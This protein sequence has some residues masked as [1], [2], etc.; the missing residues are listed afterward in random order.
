MAATTSSSGANQPPVVPQD[1]RDFINP[2][3]FVTQWPVAL[4]IED[5]SL[6]G[7]LTEL[8]TVEVPWDSLATLKMHAPEMSKDIVICGWEGVADIIRQL[9]GRVLLA[10]RDRL[11]KR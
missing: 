11:M 3:I 5:E 4:L 2:G 7:R 9:E 8:P 6:R 1:D 10:V